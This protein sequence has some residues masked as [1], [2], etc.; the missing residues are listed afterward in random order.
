MFACYGSYRVYIAW[1]A[2]EGLSGR[3]GRAGLFLLRR[4][5]LLEGVACVGR[6]AHAAGPGR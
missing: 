6:V 3:G 1:R 5:L 4:S 2:R